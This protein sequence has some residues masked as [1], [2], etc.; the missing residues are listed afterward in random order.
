MTAETP[1]TGSSR[2]PDGPIG[3]RPNVVLI[4]T[5]SQ[6]T[7]M[8]GYGGAGIVDTPN[9]DRLCANAVRFDRAYTTC[10]LCTPARAGLL[11]G[12]YAPS[13]GPWAND[14]PLGDTVPTMADHFFGAGYDTAHIGK[15]HLDGSDYFGNGLCPRGWDAEEWYDGRCYLRELRPADRALWRSGL[16]DAQAIRAAGIDRSFTWA[17]RITDRAVR[18]L[19]RP[20]RSRRPFCL[21]VSYDEPHGPSLCPPPYCDM[22]ADRPFPVPPNYRDD[23]AD[24]PVHHRA[25]AAQQALD[26]NATHLSQSLYRGAASFVDDEIGRVLSAVN[27]TCAESTIVVFTSDHGHYMGSHRLDGKGPALYE[28]VVRIPLLVRVPSSIGRVADSVVGTPVSH[29]DVLPTLLSLCGIAVPPALVG[30]TLLAAAGGRT[31][32]RVPTGRPAFTGFNRFSVSHDSWFGLMPIRAAIAA[33]YK[34]VVNLN[35]TDELYDLTDDPYELTNRIDDSTLSAVRADLFDAT[36]AEMDRTRDPFRG[37]AWLG[38]AW[39]TIPVPGWTDGERRPRPADGVYPVSFHYDTGMPAPAVGPVVVEARFPGGNVR[40]GATSADRVEVAQDIGDT[41]E[42]W[43]HWAFRAQNLNGRRVTFGFTNGEVVGPWGPAVSADGVHWGWGRT[44]V[45][46]DPAGF[47]CDFSPD[48]EQAFFGFSLLYQR[49]RADALA[50]RYLDDRAF[51]VASIGHTRSGARLPVWRIGDPRAGSDIV[52]TCRHHACEAVAS[53]V[54]EGFV[55][56]LMEERPA[57]LSEYRFHVVPFVDLDGVEA[58]DQGKAR[59]PYDHNRAYHSETIYPEIRAIMSY[60]R[61]LDLRAAIDLH[62]PYKWGGRNDHSFFVLHG[63][64]D[65]D[66][67]RR[68]SRLLQTHAAS[69]PSAFCHDPDHDL[70]FGAEQWNSGDYHAVTSTGFFRTLNPK[71]ATVL[72]VPYFG[73]TRANAITEQSALGLGRALVRALAEWAQS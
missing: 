20:Q 31:D 28:E 23:L 39:R 4:I 29:V 27:D 22:Y 35:Q 32:A 54:L 30:Q 2:S 41:T 8:T 55:T 33:R 16:G 71:L 10:P 46:H 5:D 64:P 52:L 19:R 1:V 66:E 67:A 26:A 13:V 37:Q 36:I 7:Q 47:T 3:T 43:F 57:A 63:T 58:G 21:V 69:D 40:V 24:K 34:L 14:L 17:G 45:D 38:R 11:A 44:V 51:E 60:A 42:W 62:C 50:D 73:A 56:G 59:H 15:W 18:F 68:L 61:S 49:D 25:W 12:H 65:D 9:L 6:G 48:T 53:Y 72:E 70:E